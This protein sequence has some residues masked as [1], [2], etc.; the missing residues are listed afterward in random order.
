MNNKP[1]PSYIAF[2]ACF[3][4]F[5]VHNCFSQVINFTTSYLINGIAVDSSDIWVA[6]QGG[7]SRFNFATNQKT[8]YTA[9]N[10]GLLGNIMNCVLLDASGNKWFGGDDHL[11]KFDGYTWSSYKNLNNG[12]VVGQVKNLK[13]DILGRI[14]FMNSNGSLVIKDGVIDSSI[15]YSQI[16]TLITPYDFDVDTLGHIW[17]ATGSGAIYYDGLNWTKYDTVFAQDDVRAIQVD[18]NGIVWATVQSPNPVFYGLYKFDGISWTYVPG[19]SG[20]SHGKIYVDENNNKYFFNNQV[21][22]VFKYN[23]S[24]WTV[25]NHSSGQ[26]AG[27]PVTALFVKDSI[28]YTG[29]AYTGNGPAESVYAYGGTGLNLYSIN[30]FDLPE[31]YYVSLDIGPNNLIYAGNYSGFTISN[32]ITFQNIPSPAGMGFSGKIKID[33]SGNVWGIIEKYNPDTNFIGKYDGNSWTLFYNSGVLHD[34][35]VDP[36]GNV[37]YGGSDGLIKYDGISFQTYPILDTMAF[38][39]HGEAYRLCADTAGNI[40]FGDY[41]SLGKFNGTNIILYNYHTLPFMSHYNNFFIQSDKHGNVWAF[42]ANND[43]IKFDGSGW[44][45]FNTGNLGYSVNQYY[46]DIDDDGSSLWVS[47]NNGIIKYDG[48]NFTYYDSDIYHLGCVDNY[49]FG[50]GDIAKDVNGNIWYTGQDFIGVFNPDG[51]EKLEIEPEPEITGTTYYDANI[52]GVLDTADIGLPQQTLLLQ[53][54]SVFRLSNST[55]KY[56]FYGDT[57]NYTISNLISPGWLLTSAFNPYNVLADSV[58]NCCY[59]FGLQPQTVLHQMNL[60]LINTQSRCN[61]IV[62]FGIDIYNSGTVP[63]NVRC[64]FVKDSLI[65]FANSTPA[66]TSSSDD[67]LFWDI[68]GCAPFSHH[69]VLLQLQ[70]PNQNNAG[71]T[72]NFK[73][74]VISL[75]N[76]SIFDT[77]SIND[78]VTCAYDPNDKVARP[79]GVDAPHYTLMND[80]LIYTIRFQNTGT[81]TALTVAIYDTLDANLDMN[82]FQFIASSHTVDVKYDAKGR[83]RFAFYSI[84]LPDSNTAEIASHGFVRYSIKAKQS[85]PDYTLVNNTA[86]ILFDYNVPVVT[87][88]AFNTLVIQ[89]PTVGLPHVQQNN[90]VLVYPNPAKDQI[91]FKLPSQNKTFDLMIADLFGRQ[92]YHAKE[93]GDFVSIATSK[94]GEGVFVYSITDENNKNYFGKIILIK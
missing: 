12:D 33:H 92:V 88:T 83:L 56:V 9:G 6:T 57:G 86:F 19:G 64:Y 29:T 7:V 46:C 26:I 16:P 50:I 93:N 42:A 55:G 71:D 40:W 41:Y 91:N 76:G 51:I 75:T 82:T 62:P 73:G 23:D 5:N 32:G 39:G 2:T 53:P 24:S 89:I 17:F 27:N 52:N 45:I 4:L 87:N 43:L 49:V 84:Q 63:E 79:V 21:S 69:Q 22:G 37:W 44:A 36:S 68:N 60:S 54:D 28:L 20:A 72:L 77:D 80:T 15:Y 59:D 30:A 70:M 34:F 74:G 3:I 35:T 14:L 31:N 81:D 13:Q 66:I 90:S 58:Y 67:T 61:T 18:K 1:K 65:G 11:Y 38:Q 10:S 48:V 47:T 85:T 25:Y 8:I 78:V 94:I